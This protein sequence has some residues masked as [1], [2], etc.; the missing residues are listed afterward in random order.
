MAETK[1]SLL[2]Y[3]ILNAVLQSRSRGI[4]SVD[5]AR[6]LKLSTQL[7]NYHLLKLAKEGLVQRVEAKKI[8]YHKPYVKY[9]ITLEGKK[10]SDS[11]LFGFAGG[12]LEKT[13]LDEMIDLDFQ[14]L[15]TLFRQFV[16]AIKSLLMPSQW[17]VLNFLRGT[18][19]GE[20]DKLQQ[21][22]KFRLAA[23]KASP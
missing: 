7:A 4:S 8:A 15:H 3:S 20:I 12:T 9:T 16:N 11:F 18:V 5:A 10:R 23:A 19:S 1:Q 14:N 13:G 22:M 17:E 21:A 6:Q 2:K